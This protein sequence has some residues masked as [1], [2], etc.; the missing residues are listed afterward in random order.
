[1]D[2]LESKV[3]QLAKEYDFRKA[4][5]VS[6]VIRKFL[7]EGGGVINS[8]NLPRLIRRILQEVYHIE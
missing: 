6:D 3:S 2:S 7:E 8:N 5:E 1:M 4:Y